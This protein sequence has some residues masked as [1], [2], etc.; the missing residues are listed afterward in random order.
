M[1]ANTPHTGLYLDDNVKM[2][3][4]LPSAL[5]RLS[6]SYQD[7]NKKF[8]HNSKM[9][10]DTFQ[11]F[12]IQSSNIK[13]TQKWTS[14]DDLC[15]KTLQQM[16]KYESDMMMFQDEKVALLKENIQSLEAYIAKMSKDLNEFQ[17]VLQPNM[18][19]LPSPHQET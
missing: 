6:N 9:S 13:N 4:G 15:T 10:Q 8:E 12:Q 7:L 3:T 16:R 19:K 5:I 1:A 11:T 17:K 18:I 2:V 14:K